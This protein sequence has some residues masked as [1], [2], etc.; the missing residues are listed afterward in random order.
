MEIEARPLLVVRETTSGKWGTVKVF[1]IPM[2]SRSE[3]ANPHILCWLEVA[4]PGNSAV[5]DP[6]N[7]ER[8]EITR[9][10]FGFTQGLGDLTQLILVF[11]GFA[12]QHFYGY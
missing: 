2:P 11:V 5:I 7:W 4:A 10:E 6:K 8:P 3:I 12:L 1:A 9:A